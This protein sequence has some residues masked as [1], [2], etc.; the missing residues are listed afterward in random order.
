MEAIARSR[1]QRESPRKV[2]QVLG[3]IRGKSYRDAQHLLPVISKGCAVMVG[4]TLKSAYANL[5]V[6]LGKPLEPEQAWVRS[7]WVGQ[8]PMKGLKRIQPGPQGR[9]M[10][11]K[12]KMCHL[13]IIVSDRVS[14][15]NGAKK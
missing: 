11:Y 7:C 8:G 13:T 2:A 14:G 15:P 4:K 6:R 3:S 5:L 12:R 10:P 9:A 1:F